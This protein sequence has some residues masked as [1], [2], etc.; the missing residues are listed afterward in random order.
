MLKLT[1]F[2][3]L[4]T[5]IALVFCLTSC[6]AQS[7]TQNNSAE[8]NKLVGLTG[9]DMTKVLRSDDL[10]YGDGNMLSICNHV[11]GYS[12]G[13]TRSAI[14]DPGGKKKVPLSDRKQS[15]RNA[16]ALLKGGQ[17]AFVEFSYYRK[18]IAEELLSPGSHDKYY[19]LLV[20]TCEKYLK[21]QNN[22]ESQYIPALLIQG[23]CWN[24]YSD[25]SA[26]LQEKVSGKWEYLDFISSLSKTSYC[27][28]K[29]Y[30]YGADFEVVRWLSDKDKR[31]FRIVWS[32]WNFSSGKAKEYS[33]ASSAEKYDVDLYLG[34]SCK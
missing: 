29:D 10:A 24:N 25:I 17:D 20:S 9:A 19:D 8:D 23:G 15:L 30:P 11:W 26:E 7:G 18:G 28:D 6:V 2:M 21:V 33:C 16:D 3:K 4:P 12:N 34:W 1:P 14:F 31:T 13:T 32:S 5:V 22:L 27:T